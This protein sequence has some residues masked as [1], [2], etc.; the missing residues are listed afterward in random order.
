MYD[1]TSLSIARTSPIVVINHPAL[2]ALQTEWLVH[3]DATPWKA[4]TQTV[5]QLFILQLLLQNPTFKLSSF[6]PCDF[7]LIPHFHWP[8]SREFVSLSHHMCF[9]LSQ[10]LSL[11]CKLPKKNKKQKPTENSCIPSCLCTESCQS[12]TKTRARRNS[13]GRLSSGVPFLGPTRSDARGPFFSSHRH[14]PQLCHSGP[15][16]MRYNPIVQI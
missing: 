15:R 5:Q 10:E 12:G 16:I 9:H 14:S 7:A 11:M 6:S 1:H 3:R 8:C 4:A 2:P 13:S